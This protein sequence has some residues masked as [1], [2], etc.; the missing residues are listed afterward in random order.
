MQGRPTLLLVHGSW[1]GPWCWERLIPELDN[2]G[3]TSAT[4]ALPSCGSD[5]AVLGTV[6]DD[7][8]A[9]GAAFADIAGDVVVVGHSYGGVVITQAQFDSRARHLVYLGAFMPDTAQSLFDLLPP[10]WIPRYMRDH[11][12]G[13]TTVDPAMAIDSFFADCDPS[14]AQWAA[15]M[16]RHH[17]GINNVTPV[18]RASWRQQT[19]TYVV[20][21]DDHAWPAAEQRKLATRATEQREMQTSHSP[22]L[23]RPVEL[24]ALLDDIVA[25][26]THDR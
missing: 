19:S 4:V 24:A 7:A 5:P 13:S 16:L 12:D 18:T 6:S 15:S 1:H 23:S 17:N 10:R 2:L 26:V 9:A 20:L 25:R 3:L 8:D 11:A 14:T 22:F 21:T